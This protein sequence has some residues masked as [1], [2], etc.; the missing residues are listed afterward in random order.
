MRD[1]ER[2]PDSRRIAA[3]RVALGMS[4]HASEAAPESQDPSITAWDPSRLTGEFFAHG[5]AAFDRTFKDKQD[6][7]PPVL[8]H[9][10]TSRGL[11]GILESRTIFATDMLY[12]NDSRE[13][14]RAELQRRRSVSRSRGDVF[15]T[16]P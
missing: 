4:E 16:Y 5:D 7:A 12:L 15:L 8:Y 3:A 1:V 9:Y 10:T 2:V 13:H 11:L 14:I 6:N